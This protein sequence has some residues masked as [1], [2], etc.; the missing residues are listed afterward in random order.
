MRPQHRENNLVTVLAAVLVAGVVAFAVGV[1][2]I[3]GWIQDAVVTAVR[4]EQHKLDGIESCTEAISDSV[5][6]LSAKETEH[7]HAIYGELGIEWDH[8]PHAE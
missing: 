6:R 1:P 3:K 8:G 2:V 4:Q 5:A 7:A